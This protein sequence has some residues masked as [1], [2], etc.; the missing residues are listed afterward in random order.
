VAGAAFGWLYWKKGLEAAMIAHGSADVVLHVLGPLVEGK[1]Q[2][3]RGLAAPQPEL[4]AVPE[5]V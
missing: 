5:T 4:T 3:N 1:E 2:N